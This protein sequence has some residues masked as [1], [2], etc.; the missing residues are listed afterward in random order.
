MIRHLVPPIVAGADA[1][2]VYPF[3]RDWRLLAVAQCVVR[4][5][6]RIVDIG[7]D[8]H[9]LAADLEACAGAAGRIDHFDSDTLDTTLITERASLVSVNAE[10]HEASV[11]HALT[12]YLLKWRPVLIAHAD[13]E[14]TH[15]AG[16]TLFQTLCAMRR[17]GYVV[18]EIGRYGLRRPDTSIFADD[19]YWVG[20]PC[21]R[22]ELVST[23]SNRILRCGLIPPWPGLNPMARSA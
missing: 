2:A 6:D 9:P 16:A 19:G 1:G 11:V 18:R 10:G 20:V 17:C 12:G 8:E 15:V 7:S 21:E 13:A 23:I 22:R 3:D 14:A 4:S 5:G